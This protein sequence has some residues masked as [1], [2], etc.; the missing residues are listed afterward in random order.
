MSPISASRQRLLLEARNLS[1][2]CFPEG[3][4]CSDGIQINSMLIH[5][6]GNEPRLGY[7]LYH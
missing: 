4:S 1:M 3:V 5:T 7:D 6:Q 2:L